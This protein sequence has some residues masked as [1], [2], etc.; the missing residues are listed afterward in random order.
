MTGPELEGALRAY[1]KEHFPH[2]HVDI[3]L[4]PNGGMVDVTQCEDCGA[5]DEGYASASWRLDRGETMADA[6]QRI[7]DHL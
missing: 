4:Y 3:S 1:F 6:V 5:D 7:K 2:G